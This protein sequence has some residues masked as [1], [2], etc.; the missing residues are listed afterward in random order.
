L[1]SPFPVIV[2][3]DHQNL[4]YFQ[5]AQK[6]TRRQARWQLFLSEY[7]LQFHHV[8]GTAP[9]LRT[10]D[11]LSRRPDYIA[12]DTDNLDVVLLPPNLFVSV[13]D[14]AIADSLQLPNPLDDPII[15]LAADALAGKV[16]PP[17]RSCLADW[18]YEDDILYF[19][20]RAYVPPDARPSLLHLHHQ[21][22]PLGYIALYS[23]I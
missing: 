17:P 23:T 16:S 1:G 18:H 9:L 3:T 2:Y 8:P 13:V 10:P 20:N 19:K 21:E 5:T 11:A 14:I 6:L 4:T 15:S 7:D 22:K 12:S